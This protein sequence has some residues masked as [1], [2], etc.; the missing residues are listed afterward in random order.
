MDTLGI[1]P[2]ASR[3]LSG[4]DTTTPCAQLIGLSNASLGLWI[5]LS[6]CP[7][8]AGSSSGGCS[9]P[10]WLDPLAL[11]TAPRPGPLLAGGEGARHGGGRRPSAAS[12]PV[13]AETFAFFAAF[14][15]RCFLTKNRP[16]ARR[17]P[18]NF[19]DILQNSVSAEGLQAVAGLGCLGVGACLG[20]GGP[21][22]N[23]ALQ[24]RNYSKLGFLV[25]VV[26]QE[27]FAFF[28]KRMLLRA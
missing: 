11:G 20:A 7:C 1:E 16:G 21:G 22:A 13:G 6:C 14:W 19:P 8:D 23:P 2:R 9:G 3:M 15:K 4:C 5:E 28:V 17:A 12:G 25:Q 10:S 27:G 24:A 18:Q 26:H